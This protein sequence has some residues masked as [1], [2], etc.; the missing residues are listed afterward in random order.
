V[1]YNSTTGTNKALVQI[2]ATSS[3]GNMGTAGTQTAGLAFTGSPGSSPY[4][5]NATEEYSGFNWSAG[6]NYPLSTRFVHGAGTQTAA[7]GFMSDLAPL[8]L[9]AEYDGSSWTAG[10]S[11][12][13][14]QKLIRYKNMMV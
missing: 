14:V 6:G 12:Q 4:T 3:G 2:K 7:L 5:S 8:Q 13:V 1:W 9:S 10:N 11:T